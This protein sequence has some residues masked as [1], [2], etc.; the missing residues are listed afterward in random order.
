[1]AGR[2]LGS[3]TYTPLICSW[4]VALA[5]STTMALKHIFG[6]ILPDP[7]Y[8]VDHIYEFHPLQGDLAHLAFPSGTMAISGAIMSVLWLRH[9]RLRATAMLILAV[10]AIALVI[11]NSH[12]LADLIAGLFLGAFIGRVTIL[13]LEPRDV[14]SAGGR[15]ADDASAPKEAANLNNLDDG[16][17]SHQQMLKQ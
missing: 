12:W 3:W 1:M 15:I 14:A 11:T 5:L 16:D 9:P 6:R 13:L 2:S 10:L 7:Y 8:V 17:K 4:S